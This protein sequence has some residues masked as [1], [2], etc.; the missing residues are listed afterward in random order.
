MPADIHLLTSKVA[1]VHGF[2]VS[3]ASRTPCMVTGG[4]LGSNRYAS[5]QGLVSQKSAESPLVNKKEKMDKGMKEYS[6]TQKRKCMW[7]VMLGRWPSS[8]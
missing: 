2:S 7:P 8:I 3:R 4:G 5:D 6:S 1:E